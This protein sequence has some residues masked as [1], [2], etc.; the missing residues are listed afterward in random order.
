V[1][2]LEKLF[3]N[4]NP[5]VSTGTPLDNFMKQFFDLN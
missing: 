3:E 5:S 1:L 4:G 2:S